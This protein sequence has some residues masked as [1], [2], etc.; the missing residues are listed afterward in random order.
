[1]K[2]IKIGADKETGLLLN[3]MLE[4]IGFKGLE[5]NEKGVAS[6]KIDPQALKVWST[7]FR[8]IPKNGIVRFVKSHRKDFEA[9]GLKVK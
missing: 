1:M 6:L 4:A 3:S 8:S 2:I 5:F 7:V 9:F